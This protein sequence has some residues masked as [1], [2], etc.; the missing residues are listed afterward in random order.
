MSQKMNQKAAKKKKKKT[1]ANQKRVKSKG[2]P[3]VE[4]PEEEIQTFGD[5][6]LAAITP[7]MTTI[8]FAVIAGFLGFA[9]IT[10]LVRSSADKKAFEWRELATA[11]SIANRTNETSHWKNVA[12]KYPDSKAGLWASQLAGDMQLRTG[13]E[14]LSY[15]REAGLGKIKKSKDYFQTVIDAPDSV[16]T[17]MLQQA[18]NFSMAYACESLGEFDESKAIY[19]KLLEEAP[20]SAFAEVARRGVSRS[21]NSDYASLYTK[22]ENWEEEMIGEAPGLKLPE[23]PQIDFP[24]DEDL[25]P[26]QKPPTTSGIAPAVGATTTGGGVTTVVESAATGPLTGDSTATT[27]IT[28]PAVGDGT[29]ATDLPP[30]PRTA[31]DGN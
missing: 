31:G 7:Y 29:P 22:F 14:E 21:S 17:P 16:K 5:K 18:S 20:E 13:L 26:G 23:R 11:T 9:I 4:E 19:E 6:I 24:M 28:T 1:K 27:T 10:F 15:N 2:L 12:D 25:P 8:I 30:K 3:V